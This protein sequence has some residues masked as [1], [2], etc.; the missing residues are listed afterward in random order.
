M[1]SVKTDSGYPH[2]LRSELHKVLNAA[3]IK[4]WVAQGL[5]FWNCEDGRE[6]VAYGFD[7]SDGTPRLAVKV[8]GIREPEQV[9]AMTMGA[10]TCYYIPD[11]KGFTW[12]DE[13]DVE[14]YEEY[15]ASE[16]CYSASCDKCGH[17]MMVGD[18]GWFD[19]WDEITEW[20]E[21][22]GSEHKGYI[23]KPRFKFCPNCGARVVSE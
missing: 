9:I 21:E 6:C 18:E 1:S 15:S 14:H 17:S 13:S 11:E 22:D 20:T 4:Y 2:A 23:L 19:G 3:G 8:V 5:T 10:G 12:W 7:A 16:E